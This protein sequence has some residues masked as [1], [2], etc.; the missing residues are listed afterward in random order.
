MI[1]L[2]KILRKTN[3]FFDQKQIELIIREYPDWREH[4]LPINVKDKV[5]L[6]IGARQGDTARFFL[7][8]GAKKVICIENNPYHFKYLRQNAKFHKEIFPIFESFKLGHLILDHDF[9]KIDIEGYEE[10]LLDWFDYAKMLLGPCVVELHTAFLTEKFHKEGFEIK[11]SDLGVLNSGLI[12]Y[13][14]WGK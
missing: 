14:Y 4:Y 3:W 11:S 6:D 5:V 2:E 12:S 13:G 9:L 1:R 10:E 8:H 7:E